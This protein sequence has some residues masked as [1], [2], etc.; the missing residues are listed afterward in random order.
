MTATDRTSDGLYWPSP[1]EFRRSDLLDE[2]DSVL[3]Y[4]LLK[5]RRETD[6][7]GG[8][9]SARG[10][11]DKA[12]LA[13]V[14]AGKLFWRLA[15]WALEHHV[16]RSCGWRSFKEVC[17][18]Q[19]ITVS[20]LEYDTLIFGHIFEHLGHH[21]YKYGEDREVDRDIICKILWAILAVSNDELSKLWA[22]ASNALEALRHGE[23]KDILKP[24]RRS[25]HGVR[26]TLLR[27][28]SIAVWYANFLH[29]QGVPRAKL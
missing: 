3:L 11:E 21:C 25:S 2:D 15:G 23:V 24:G 10:K 14:G 9:E 20:R 1:E 19:G 22:D 8:E 26:Y 27:Q 29:G 5:L 17:A 12:F 7:A 4:D 6:P 13:I 18:Q 28:R 16:G